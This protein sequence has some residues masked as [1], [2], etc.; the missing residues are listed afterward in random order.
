VICV[1]DEAANTPAIMMPYQPVVAA[2]VDEEEVGINCGTEDFGG[3]DAETS[4]DAG[5]ELGGEG[6][7]AG[8]LD[9]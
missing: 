6:V 1:S 8:V 5:G 7:G 4:E 3:A 9:A 2:L